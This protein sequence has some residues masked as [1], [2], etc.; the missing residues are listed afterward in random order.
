VTQTRWV[1]SSPDQFGAADRAST[2]SNELQGGPAALRKRQI[3][4][5]SLEHIVALAAWACQWIEPTRSE[6]FSDTSVSCAPRYDR[7]TNFS[8]RHA[9]THV[10]YIGPNS[11]RDLFFCVGYV[12]TVGLASR[13]FFFRCILYLLCREKSGCETSSEL[14]LP[15]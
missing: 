8:L 3:Q 14:P 10:H 1:L 9:T 13:H 11:C 5:C 12:G 6:S 15:S 7:N 4:F 2:L